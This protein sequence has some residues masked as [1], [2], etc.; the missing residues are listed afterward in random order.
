MEI[1]KLYLDLIQN[2][3]SKKT[4]KD[5]IKYYKEIDNQKVA[6]AFKYLLEEKYESDNSNTNTQ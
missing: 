1:Y 3:Y 2:P 6:E 4:Y 5:L